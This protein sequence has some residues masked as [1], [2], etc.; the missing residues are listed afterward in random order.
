ML[1][2]HQFQENRYQH[3]HNWLSW[4]YNDP[5]GLFLSQWVSELSASNITQDLSL[6]A[7]HNGLVNWLLRVVCRKLT[8]DHPLSRGETTISATNHIGHSMHHIGYT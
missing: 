3:C 7:V 8:A 4:Y 5:V 6:S 2:M 1:N